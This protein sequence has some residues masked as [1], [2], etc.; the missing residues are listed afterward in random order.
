MFVFVF[1]WESLRLSRWARNWK[2]N[3]WSVS[4]SK[5]RNMNVSLVIWLF[6]VEESVC[7]VTAST[8][9]SH[10]LL[11]HF[12]QASRFSLQFDACVSS[13]GFSSFRLLI[14]SVPFFVHFILRLTAPALSSPVIYG[15]KFLIATLS[16]LTYAHCFDS[17]HWMPTMTFTYRNQNKH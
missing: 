4:M 12:S 16:T 5:T 1:V 13:F 2:L 3:K 11:L 17:V 8:A 6:L 15:T 14:R 7:Y 9:A 10:H